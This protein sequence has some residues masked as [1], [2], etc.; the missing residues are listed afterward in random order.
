MEKII[1]PEFRVSYP[2]VFKPCYF[3][4]NKPIYPAKDDPKYDEA[5]YRLTLIFDKKTDLSAI[6]LLINDAIENKWPDLKLRPSNI[7]S[8]FR[9]GSEKG[10]KAGYENCNFAAATKLSDRGA[11]VLV[12]E[13]RD[14]II[15]P[16]E[17]Y[18]GCYARAQI[19]AF[20]WKFAN[21]HG[22]SF[23]LKMIQKLRDGEPFAEDESTVEEAFSP[24]N[25]PASDI[26]PPGLSNS[27]LFK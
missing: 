21:K 19:T 25:V 9:D 7:S 27:N 12:D 4:D 18:A 3:V 26:V 13:N 16:K 8:P 14:P 23:G 1:T 24:E 10:G 2:N 15:D 20:G 17:F 5:K 22:I 11:P 6:Q